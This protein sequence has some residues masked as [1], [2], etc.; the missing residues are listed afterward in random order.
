MASRSG[1]WEG[2]RKQ[3]R[4]LE[5]DIDLKLVTFSK[6]GTNY[7]KAQNEDPDKQPLLGSADSGLDSLQSEI[8][9]LL[10][11]LSKINEEMAGYAAGVGEARSAAIHHTLQ[12]HS[13]ILQVERDDF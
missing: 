7:S 5:N 4:A 6:L 12:R 13:E 9:N 8:D 3:A 11:N 2:L 10:T 1:N